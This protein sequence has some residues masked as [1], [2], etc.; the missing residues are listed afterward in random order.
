MK[1]SLVIGNWKSNGSLKGNRALLDAL[2]S[3][4]P[5][6]VRSAVCVPYP[7][8]AQVEQ[9]LKGSAIALGSQDVSEHG[10]GAYTG[11]VNAEM[12]VEFGCRFVIV[13]HSERR[14]LFGESDE[15][16]ARKAGA[17]LDVGMMPVVCVGETLA[18]RDA[19]EVH[20][21]LQRQLDALDS[22]LGASRLSG[23][24]VAYEPVWA[25]G[26]GRTPTREQ[27]QDALGFVRAWFAARIDDSGSVDV[28]YGGSVKAGNAVE[29]FA[30][31]DCDG[32]L[33][34]GASLVAD[35]FVAICAAAAGGS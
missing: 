35:E 3:G 20:A 15:T 16:V 1:S 17:V 33:I 23:L 27:V 12:L 9:V 6:G 24:V 4:V 5:A 11:E 22:V 34:G 14:G 25:I 2:L 29:L 30:L 21:V 32:G 10:F 28:L 13:G 19:G 31:P 8:L 7:Y 26:T 18:Q